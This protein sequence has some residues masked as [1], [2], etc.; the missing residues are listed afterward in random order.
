MSEYAILALHMGADIK[1]HVPP[2]ILELVVWACRRQHSYSLVAMSLGYVQIVASVRDS[3]Q[4][5][6]SLM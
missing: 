6:V 3:P 2:C 5:G 1:F 4:G